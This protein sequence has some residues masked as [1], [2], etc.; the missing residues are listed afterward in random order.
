MRTFL[1]TY[2]KEVRIGVSVLAILLGVAASIYFMHR[3]SVKGAPSFRREYDLVLKTYDGKDV[4]LAS[5]K[6]KILIV[7]AWASWCPYCKAEIEN[8]STLA[9]TNKNDVQIIAVNR[10]ESLSDAK[11]YSDRLVVP[12][13]VQFFLDPTDSFYKELGGYAMPETLFIDAYGHVLYQQR[14]PMKMEDMI[15]KMKE[16]GF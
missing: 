15:Q 3:Y 4:R 10:G 14:G 12:A 11:P 13:T 8:L 2:H 9:D 16:L 7:T 6:N 1:N 5:F